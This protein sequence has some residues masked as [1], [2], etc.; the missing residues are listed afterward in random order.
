MKNKQNLFVDLS[1]HFALDNIV[2]T[3]LLESKRRYNMAK[4][5]FNSGTSIGGECS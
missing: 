4:Q 2:Y 1:Y 3:E 5:L